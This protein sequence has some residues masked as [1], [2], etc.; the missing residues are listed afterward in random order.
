MVR[1]IEKSQVKQ[2]T[3]QKP[4]L[5][6][7]SVAPIKFDVR[8]D[9]Q[10][11]NEPEIEYAPPKPKALPYDSDI[12]PRGS[13]TF[14]GLK[15]E[16]LLRGY[17]ERYHDQVDE[18]GVRL[19]DK[20]FEERKEKALQEGD[21]RILRDIEN[22]DWSVADVPET[23]TMKKKPATEAPRE[24]SKAVR[25]LKHPPT[26]ASRHA[27]SALSMASG[28]KDRNA[29]APLAP[30]CQ[31]RK[32]I[33]LLSGLKKSAKPLEQSKTGVQSALGETASRSTIGYTKG[34]SAS[35]I[36]K[37]RAPLS[38]TASGASVASDDSDS[39]ITPANAHLKLE[40]A[41]G[42]IDSWPRPQ[43]LNIFDINEDSDD[44]GFDAS[45]DAGAEEE[46][47]ELKLGD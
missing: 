3:V 8:N 45:V 18:D 32:P 14:E 26:I 28:L 38:R 22:T 36:V 44:E 21:E 16:N 42:G 30:K 6:P 17:Y 23:K 47:F 39:T 46:E 43:F 9:N 19:K 13:L 33:S 29:R 7:V 11:T 15:K 2:T 27:A 5:K 1:E 41:N 10:E 12:L 34:R 25:S 24:A 31:N 20:E 40:P 35:S 4:K 37:S